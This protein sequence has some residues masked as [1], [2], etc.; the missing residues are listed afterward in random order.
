MDGPGEANLIRFFKDAQPVSASAPLP[1]SSFISPAIVLACEQVL[2]SFH[3]LPARRHAP[4]PCIV[5]LGLPGCVEAA[6]VLFLE[7]AGCDV[8]SK[9]HHAIPLDRSRP[10]SWVAYAD[11]IVIGAR[12]PAM[13]SAPW[14]RSGTVIID[15]GA[16][17][18]CAPPRAPHDAP[19]DGPIDHASVQR[20]VRCVSCHDGL[21]ALIAAIRMHNACNAALLQQGFVEIREESASTPSVSTLR[22]RGSVVAGKSFS[23]IDVQG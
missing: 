10:E 15:I 3:I 8:Q 19:A 4:R 16:S 2:R 6:L 17:T 5:L 21:S 11:A 12:Q 13:V 9:T 1:L 14:V 18:S 20:D 7:M 23:H 22:A